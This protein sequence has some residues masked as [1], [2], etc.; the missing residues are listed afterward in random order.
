MQIQRIPFPPVG[1]NM[2]VVTQ[3]RDAI[4]LDPWP[5]ETTMQRLQGYH[6][7]LVLTHEHVDHIS[8]LGRMQRALAARTLWQENCTP[9]LRNPGNTTPV[10]L[11]ARATASVRPLFS[12]ATR[13]CRATPLSRACAGATPP[14]SWTRPCHFCARCR[15]SSC[16]I[17]ATAGAVCRLVR[18]SRPWTG[19]AAAALCTC[20][21]D[22]K[23]SQ[24]GLTHVSKHA[25]LTTAV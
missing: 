14:C 7:L 16:S 15:R 17:P 24:K 18:A 2:Y 12:A 1:S 8:G 11:A 13:S 3:G 9:W 6:V 23:L 5:D 20:T 10:L 19:D 22:R 25:K 21:A 4:V